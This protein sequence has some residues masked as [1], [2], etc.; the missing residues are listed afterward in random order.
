MSARTIYLSRLI[1]LYSLL[2]AVALASHKDAS[3]EAVTALVHNPP[4]VMLAAMFASG[5]GLAIVLGHNIWFGGAPAVVVTFIGWYSLFK[6]LILFFL[7][8]AS[9]VNYFEGARYAQ[10]F[11]L[12]MG[13][14]FL[15]G[16]YLTYAGFARRPQ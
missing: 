2:V 5:A 7:P 4:T 10:F 8:P 13:T 16:A 15:L 11:Y 3:I 12:Y 9:L 14:A 6:G 1:G